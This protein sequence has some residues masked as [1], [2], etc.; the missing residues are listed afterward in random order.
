[1]FRAADLPMA[2]AIPGADRRREAAVGSRVGVSH[3]L[4][5]V[6]LGLLDLE[7]GEDLVRLVALGGE[8]RLVTPPGRI[9]RPLSGARRG[10]PR[11]GLPSK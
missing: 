4:V 11:W 1:M 8:F 10:K 9:G 3:L 6:D 2:H 7:F 5:A